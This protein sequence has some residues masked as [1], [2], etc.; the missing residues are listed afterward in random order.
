MREVEN[1][2]QPKLE[3]FLNAGSNPELLLFYILC[4]YLKGE[5][6]M[7][8]LGNVTETVILKKRKV[9]GIECDICHRII[10][11]DGDYRTV[12]KRRYFRVTT[13]HH[14]W[15]NDSCESIECRDI[16]PECVNNFVAEYLG[17]IKNTDSNYIDIETVYAY[18]HIVSDDEDD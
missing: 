6:K 16:C 15:G 13:G 1:V 2:L 5:K 18:P 9:E 11:A 3:G 12:E 4:S 10:Q 7:R 17:K 14:D 8:I